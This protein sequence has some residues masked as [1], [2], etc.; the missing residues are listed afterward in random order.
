MEG[1]DAATVC[2]EN[3]MN[4]NIRANKSFGLTLLSFLSSLNKFVFV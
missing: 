2:Q 3:E 4:Y 1:L